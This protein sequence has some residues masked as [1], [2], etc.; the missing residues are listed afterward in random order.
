MRTS[1]AMI[2]ALLCL[3]PALAQPPQPETT[4]PP[5]QPSDTTNPAAT[6]SSFISACN[7]L[8]RLVGSGA[9]ANEQDSKVLPAKER[10]LD[11]L[12][13]SQLPADIRSSAGL[14]SALFLKEVLDRIDL[15]PPGEIPTESDTE[16]G[17]G[18]KIS[19]K[20]PGTRI[21]IAQIDAPGEQADYRFTAETVRRAAEYYRMVRP[22]P[23]RSTG[24]EISPDLH[25]AYLEATKKQPNVSADT[26]SPRGTLT[27]FLDACNELHA[28]IIQGG[29]FDRSNPEFERVAQRIIACLDTSQLPEYS[30]EY[31]DAEAAV[32]LK[33]VL[34][35]VSLPPPEQ[36]PGIESIEATSGG[37]ALTRWQVPSTQITIARIQDGPRQGEFLFTAG[38]VAAAPSLF[39][40][41]REQPYRTE[42][43]AVSQG[44]Y[45]WWL[46]SPG[47]P[48]VAAIVDRLPDWANNR[49]LRLA[50]WQWAGL[51]MGIFISLA[52][53]GILIFWGR[54]RG[55]QASSRGLLVPWM[56]FALLLVAAGIPFLFKQ[57]AWH[58]LTIR[59]TPI[60]A[61]NF[62]S[63]VVFLLCIVGL[64]VNG[65]RRTAE[66]IIAFRRDSPGGLDASLTRI[67]SQV[68]GIVLAAVVFLEGGRYL[69]F[70]VTTL[71][72][73]AGIGG[74]ALALSAQGLIQGLFGTVTVLMDKPYR[75]GDW[76][77]VNSHEGVVE[78]I[79]LRST[80][81][82]GL[83]NHLIC[84]PNDKLADAEIE[85]IGKRDR[86]CRISDLH[87]P[88]DT[89]RE[90]VE[91]A[92]ATI[93][94][95]LADHEGMDADFPPRV[96]FNEF[97]AGSF[98]IRIIYWYAPP[99]VWQYYA[100]CERVNLE[101][102]KAF[103]QLGIQ[104]SLP[105]R[106]SYWKHDDQQGPLEV[107]LRNQKEQSHESDS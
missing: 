47:H 43:R 21:Q 55:A 20:I 92:V 41:R 103:E 104:F 18:A 91:Q 84:L 23:Y 44:F 85:N 90:H 37:E 82:R 95:I 50:V 1:L 61:V 98:N 27:Q 32:C 71:I 68:L 66:T 100:F 49:F 81:I 53:M 83:N 93:R 9:V 72:A 36:I 57:F 65:C 76:I 106:H 10:I 87:I 7:E 75:V 64:I 99:N 107:T 102:F 67:I 17:N 4:L 13:L 63:D 105:Q 97:N 15:P 101:V 22:L 94:T 12:D 29:H 74:L 89:P 46:S 2:L 54:I 33:E 56:G 45:D 58:Y 69:G 19:W 11:C 14:E 30:R 3:A 78:D 62:A 26:S 31:F 60:Y 48:T 79:G 59:S 77:K 8:F 5:L 42:G 40:K 51:A 34:D 24:R 39:A 88:L 86:I 6:L 38:T 16:A 28:A 70:P 25:D 80:K 35:R 73:S 96:F 52:M